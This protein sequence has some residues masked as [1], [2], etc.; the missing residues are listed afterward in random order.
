MKSPDLLDIIGDASDAHIR[1]AKSIKKKVIPLWAKWSSAI[2]ACLVIVIGCLAI[3]PQFYAPGDTT[4]SNGGGSGHDEGMV[5]MSYAGPV[6]PLTFT[7]NCDSISAA[8]HIDFNFA[9]Y[10][11]DIAHTELWRIN[12]RDTAILDT[13]LLTNSSQ[14]D[15]TITGLYPFVGDFRTMNWPAITVD[16]KEIECT[17]NV[18]GYSGGWSGAGD[19]ISTSLNLDTVNSWTEYRDLLADGS[20]IADAFTAPES[21][22]QPAIV[23]K[24][25]DLTDGA[26]EYDA[27][28]LCL[29]FKYDP[30]KTSIMTWGFNGGGVREDTGDEYRDFFIREGRR[31]ADEDVKYFV[32]VGDDIESYDIQGY[33][34]GSCTPGQEIDDASATVTRVEMTIGELLREI[35][36]IRYDAII[37]ND[38]D[39]DHNRYLDKRISFEMYYQAVVKHFSSY[40]PIGTTPMERYQFGM[41]DDIIDETAYHGRIFYLS[42]DVTIPAGSSVE[43]SVEQLKS[44]SFDFHCGS[45][46]EGIDGYDMVTTLGSNIAFS[47]QS[48][49]IS[50]YDGIE[51]VRQ[52][53][54]FDLGGGITQVDLDMNEPHYYLEVREFKRSE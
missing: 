19:E 21:L 17:L 18:G 50:N 25:S 53:F 42:F 45:D 13:Y 38:F 3:L 41:L 49:S 8:R 31:L 36:K 29:S 24:L 4:P 48:A 39:G 43:V 40:G 22:D 11:E 37:D 9:S 32:A 14:D 51:I 23:Y 2:A 44:A 15:I 46:N 20:Y 16:G 7:E 28:S 47:E 10:L 26:G 5:F 12:V 27:A 34:D 6:F 54:G 35:S 1:D 30:A 33:L 52:N